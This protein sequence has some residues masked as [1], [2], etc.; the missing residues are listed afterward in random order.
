[1]RGNQPCVFFTYKIRYGIQNNLGTFYRFGYIVGRAINS[2]KEV[3][4]AIPILHSG[5]NSIFCDAIIIGRQGLARLFEFSYVYFMV[6]HPVPS[7]IVTFLRRLMPTRSKESFYSAIGF[8]NRARR[9]F[10]AT[11]CTIS[12]IPRTS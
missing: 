9:F 1:M 2:N 8:T 4:F 6:D 10:T 5:D 12:N 3:P 11:F 7:S